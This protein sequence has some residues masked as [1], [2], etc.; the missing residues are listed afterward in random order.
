MDWLHAIAVAMILPLATSVVGL[1]VE[2]VRPFD[3]PW[4]W[5]AVAFN[6]LHLPVFLVMVSL[7]E[8]VIPAS[9]AGLGAGMEYRVPWSA[10]LPLQILGALGFFATY[11]F[12][13]YWMHRA[14][15]TFP[16]LWAAHELHHSDAGVNVTTRNRTHWLEAPVN[17]AVVVTPTLMLWQ[18][19]PAWVIFTVTTWSYLIHANLKLPFGP[20]TRVFVG[21]YSHRIHHSIDEAHHNRNF[22]SFFVPWDLLFG[23]FVDPRRSPARELGLTGQAPYGPR[24]LVGANLRPVAQ[25]VRAMGRLAR[26]G[27]GRVRSG[28]TRALRWFRRSRTSSTAPP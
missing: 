28:G 4:P 8:R 12:F 15:H 5:R 16:V 1:A 22:A 20:L 10:S 9:L 7:I 18:A 21:P 3:R 17:F 2:R 27:G 24:D 14:Q 25:T 23:T 6:L 26:A 11:D 19:P 13:Y